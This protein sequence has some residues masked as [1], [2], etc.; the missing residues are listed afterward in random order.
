MTND[1]KIE[2]NKVNSVGIMAESRY[3]SM[4]RGTSNPNPSKRDK[5]RTIYH[6]P[7]NDEMAI[8][9]LATCSKTMCGCMKTLTVH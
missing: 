7:V 5:S 9:R 8:K 3:L 4:C 2:S 6:R 1:A